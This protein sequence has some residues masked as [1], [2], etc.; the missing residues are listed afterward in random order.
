MS[1]FEKVKK[2]FDSW[3]NKIDGQDEVVEMKNA[4]EKAKEHLLSLYTEGKDKAEF[5]K[6]L[7]DFQNECYQD[8]F[9]QGLYAGS[10]D[11]G[12]TE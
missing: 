4:E 12:E 8:G 7:N 9:A 1:F 5:L 10:M 6:A 2:D 3:M 11:A